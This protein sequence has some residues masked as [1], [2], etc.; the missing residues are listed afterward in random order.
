LWGWEE[1]LLGELRSVLANF[2]LQPN[3][4]DQWVWRYHPDGGYSIRGAY[5]IFTAQDAQETAAKSDLIWH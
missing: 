3:V 5:E 1:E 4:V 2:V